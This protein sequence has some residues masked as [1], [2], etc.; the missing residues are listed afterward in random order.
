MDFRFGSGNP[1]R[2]P[3]ARRQIRVSGRDRTWFRRKRQKFQIKLPVV[4]VRVVG[5][6]KN[7]PTEFAT[8]EISF[9]A[10]AFLPAR[11][12]FTGSGLW[13]RPAC[14][15]GSNSSSNSS[16][17]R[18]S[19]SHLKFILFSCSKVG[20]WLFSCHGLC[21]ELGNTLIFFTYGLNLLVNQTKH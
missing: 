18:A 16:S 20:E 2:L 5:A 19:I 11:I 15:G 8:G 17:S 7:S 6:Q 3:A 9:S 14:G 10:T 13:C 12:F 1:P 4:A 21:N